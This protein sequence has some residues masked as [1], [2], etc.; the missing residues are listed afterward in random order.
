[1]GMCLSTGQWP[2]IKSEKRLQGTGQK[3]TIRGDT[4]V[5]LKTVAK[6]IVLGW[7]IK[8]TMA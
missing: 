6:F 2:L 8:S 4:A 3:R 5:Q 7:G 1:M